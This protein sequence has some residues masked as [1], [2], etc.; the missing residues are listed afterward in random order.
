MVVGLRLEHDHPLGTVHRVAAPDERDRAAD[1]VAVVVV[2]RQRVT[3]ALAGEVGTGAVESAL[4][5]RNDL[6]AR[7]AS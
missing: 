4:D 6:V 1:E 2:R 7:C 3:E 5:E